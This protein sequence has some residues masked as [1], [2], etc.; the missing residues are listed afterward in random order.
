MYD[1]TFSRV[2]FNR[3]FDHITIDRTNALESITLIDRTDA[4]GFSI[5]PLIV[6]SSIDHSIVS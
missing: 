3:S 5:E 1:Q 6:S 4:L 2:M